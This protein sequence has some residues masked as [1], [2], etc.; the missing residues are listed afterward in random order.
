MSNG[1]RISYVVSAF[2]R[3][4]FV[5]VLVMLL[6]IVAPEPAHAADQV[7]TNTNDSGAGSL[8][9]AIADVGAGETN[10]FDLSSYPTTITLTSGELVINKNLTITGPSADLLTI[11]SE[12]T[13]R[14]FNV[15][16]GT[17]T[18][19]GLTI[20]DGYVIDNPAQGGGVY[21]ASGAT[22]TLQ[23]VTV[24]HNTAEGSDLLA[25]GGIARGGG[26]HSDGTL[27][28]TASTISGNYALGGDAL[29][30]PYIGGSGEGGGIYSSSFGEVV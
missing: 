28:V 22:L 8:R 12:F 6:L 4:S 2:P 27:S 16:S 24:T 25:L 26:I 30:P 9:Q 20:R 17:A 19:S 23:L 7:V 10:T 3:L 15:S 29:S 21:V 1:N 18:I 13:S 14:V 5:V 11:R